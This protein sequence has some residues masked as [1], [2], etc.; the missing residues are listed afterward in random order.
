ML[1]DGTLAG[2]A[3][4]PHESLNTGERVNNAT[5]DNPLREGVRLV[6]T[7]GPCTVVIFG[8]SG[9]LTK[10]KLVP[11]LYRLVQQRLLPAEFAIVGQARTPMTDDEFR[12]KMKQSVAEFSEAK[13]VDEDVW[14]L[15]RRRA[16]TTCR[17]TSATR[18][19]TGSSAT[20]STASTE[21][22]AP[23]ATACSIFRSR[24]A[25]MRRRCSSSAAPASRKPKAGS[26]VRVIIEKPFGHDLASA[27]KLN[28]DIHESARRIADLS[29][30]SLSRQRDG[31]EPAGLP[32]RQRHLRAALEPP[33]HRPRADHQRRSRRRRGPRRLLRDGRRAARHDPEP[34][35]PG[36]CRSS[37]WSRRRTWAPNAVRDEK[38][39]VMYVGARV[40]SRAGRRRVRARPVRPRRDRR[41]AGAGLSPGRR[42]R[43]RFD[44]RDLRA[45]SRSTS[46]TGA[47]RVCRSICA[48]A[49]G[50][51]SASPRSRSSSRPR[52]ISSSARR[53]W[54]R[55][56]PTCSSSASSRTKASRF[57]S[58]RRSRARSR[59]YAT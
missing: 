46:T 52:R 29:H 11:A 38:I 54:R 27:R 45:R 24:R 53:S 39:K 47:G 34:R 23:R 51:R 55:C 14:R 5:N 6:R 15:V 49:S 30:R 59:T 48:R 50:C 4:R 58:R 8:A 43:A 22:A 9:D 7:A 10:R 32:L 21:S 40:H 42:R 28:H 33:V 41:Q 44:D 2:A 37:P 35:V 19:T 57:A 3:R 31:A 20:S 36:A 25:S 56:S 13:Q 12:D 26:W 1:L 17:R 16:S 18:T